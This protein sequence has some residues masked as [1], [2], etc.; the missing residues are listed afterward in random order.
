MV[1][2]IVVF[3]KEFCEKIG[4]GMM[5]CKKVF[6]EMDGDFEVVV[7]WLCK[8]G[9]F[10]VVKKVD[11]VVVEGLVVVV[12]DGVNGVVVEVNF[13]ID[14]VVCNEK[15]QVVVVEIVKL[16]L[17]IEGMVDVFNVVIL[18]FGEM[19]EVILINLIVMI[20]ENMFLCCV[21]K[22]D[23][24]MG[25]VFFYVYNVV[26]DGMG[27]LGVI[28]VFKFD[29]DVGKLVELGCK[30]VMYV[31][32]GFLAVVVVVDID[33]VDSV[34]VDKECEVFVDQVCQFGKL[35]QIVEKM[36]EGCM[37]KF[38]EEVVLLKQFFVMDLDNM[39]EQVLVNV[40]KELGMLVEIVGFQCVVLGEGVEKKEEDFVVEVVV[41]I[42]QV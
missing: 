39:I 32:V 28:V 24:G 41:V 13:E 9:L 2:I 21:F 5:D 19:V 7:D 18:L 14:F 17:I 15:F 35:E 31:V 8:K 3:V 38:Y 22:L 40:F 36:V 4:V 27:V 25:V 20:G 29:G 42:G 23:V 26:V 34:I 1:V 11:C 30:I 6:N 16:V 37:C 10:K 33:G 12:I